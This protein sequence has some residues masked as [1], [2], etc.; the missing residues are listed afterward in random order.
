LKKNNLIIFAFGANSPH[1]LFTGRHI[2]KESRKLRKKEHIKYS[3]LLEE[4][5]KRNEFEDITIL[6]NCLSEVNLK[7]I[8]ISTNLQD[9]KLASPIIINAMTGGMEEGEKI[10]SQLS[11]IAK[12]LNIAMAVGSQK[13]AL[14]NPKSARSFEIVRKLNPDGIIF[15]N[16]GADATVEEAN[17]AIEMIKADA[18]Q[19]HLNVP[20]EVIMK[21]GRRDFRGT[22]D[23]IAEIVRNV[24]VPVI[25]KEVGFGIAR[26]EAVELLE[27]GVKIIDVGGTGGSN[28][29]A[30]ERL[31]RGSNPLKKFE[32]WGRP[33]PISLIE[34][35]TTVGS[36]ADVIASGGLKDGLDAAKS[37]ALGAKA[38]AYA[39]SILHILY[40]KGPSGLEKHIL[41]IEKEIKYVMAMTGASNLAELRKRPV[42]IK[43]KTYHWMKYRGISI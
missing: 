5:L 1:I 32:D 20:Q 13:I 10:N 3:L 6:H 41:Q 35:L 38:V 29:I 11:R 19:L 40:N 2:M 22:V 30:I 26:E 4:R 36:K 28:F 21:E 14:D 8:D 17:M 12:K 42:I 27:K 34:V 24:R 43:G 15:A 16:L 9:I 39:G 18:L 25:V 23:N 37:I 31:R 7:E 33:T